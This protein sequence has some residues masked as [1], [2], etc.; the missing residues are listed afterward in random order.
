MADTGFYGV[1]FVSASR[2]SSEL[3]T[4]RPV[5]GVVPG[6]SLKFHSKSGPVRYTPL[7]VFALQVGR[8]WHSGNKRRMRLT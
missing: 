5:M 3:L 6:M 7:W 4:L 8:E 1:N 2:L